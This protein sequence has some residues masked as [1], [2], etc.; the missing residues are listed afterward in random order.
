MPLQMTLLAYAQ[1]RDILRLLKTFP[2]VT[3]NVYSNPTR[4]SFFK[5][6]VTMSSTLLIKDV[7]IFDGENEISSGSVLVENGLIKRVSEG[8][9]NAP[10]AS[11]VVISK[12]GHTLIPGIRSTVSV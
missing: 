12:P 4:I 1:T 8:V 3:H 5:Y 7:R 9:L 11:T 10:D 2:K 6:P